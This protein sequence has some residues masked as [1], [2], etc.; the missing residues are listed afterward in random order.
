MVKLLRAF[1]ALAVA[2]TAF[3]TFGAGAAGAAS[4]R[5]VVASAPSAAANCA[6]SAKIP[7]AGLIA[8]GTCPGVRPGAVVLTSVGQCTLNFEFFGADGHRYMGTAGHCILG[9]GELES[10]QGEKSWAQGAGPVATDINGTPIGR[11]R[12]AIEQDPKDFALIELFDNVPATAQVCGFGGPTGINRD[13]TDTPTAL[14]LFGQGLVIGNIIP[15][16]TL[17]ALSL[18]NPNQ[19][20]AWGLSLPGDSGSPVMTEDG[21]AVGVL[22]TLGVDLSGPIGITRIGP[23]L[24][25]ASQVLGFPI[26]IVTAPKL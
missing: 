15:G 9:V 12:Y 23:Q 22:V 25:R 6:A 17:L 18:S 14:T 3:L 2:T 24:D 21:R 26:G 4:A 20:Q 7:L 19:V 16:R 1:A 11:F 8:L 13:I 5:T 10:N